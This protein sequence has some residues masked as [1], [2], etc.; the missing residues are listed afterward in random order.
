MISVSEHAISESKKKYFGDMGASLCKPSSKPPRKSDEMDDSISEVS[1]RDE[2]KRV[3]LEKLPPRLFG[4]DVSKATL[5]EDTILDFVVLVSQFTGPLV[6]YKGSVWDVPRRGK[7][8]NVVHSALKP[9]TNIL[10]TSDGQYQLAIWHLDDPTEKSLDIKV[11]DFQVTALCDDPGAVAII[12]GSQSGAVYSLSLDTRDYQLALLVTTASP[13]TLISCQRDFIL[14]ALKSGE[15]QVFNPA[16]GQVVQKY[17]GSPIISLAWSEQQPDL[18]VAC[19]TSPLSLKLH[20]ARAAVS[21]PLAVSFD[22]PPSRITWVGKEL[23][24]LTSDGLFKIS[25]PNSG[26]PVLV[27]SEISDC[28]RNAVLLKSGVVSP[29]PLDDLEFS[30]CT[31]LDFASGEDPWESLGWIIRQVV[32]LKSPETE[33]EA[34]FLSLSESGDS[35]RS[36]I[37]SHAVALNLPPLLL[38]TLPDPSAVALGRLPG[39]TWLLVRGSA[40]GGVRADIL[41]AAPSGPQVSD[42]PELSMPEAVHEG[43]RI[44][45][46]HVEARG[47]GLVLLIVLDDSGNLSISKIQGNQEASVIYATSLVRCFQFSDGLLLTMAGSGQNVSLER[48]QI[49]PRT[50]TPVDDDFGWPRPDVVDFESAWR[51]DKCFADPVIKLMPLVGDGSV[52]L[53]L[54]AAE[55]AIYPAGVSEMFDAP[56]TDAIVYFIED[57][58]LVSVLF[59]GVVKTYVID[60]LASSQLIGTLQLQDDVVT[61]LAPQSLVAASHRGLVPLLKR[62]LTETKRQLEEEKAKKIASLQTAAAAASDARRDAEAK[63]QAAAEEAARLNTT[64]QAVNALFKPLKDVTAQTVRSVAAPL[65]SVT[66][67]L[68]SVAADFAKVSEGV[69]NAVTHARDKIRRNVESMAQLQEQTEEMESDAADFARLAKQL[70]KSI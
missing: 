29:Y 56:A 11:V 34:L 49:W 6:M 58:Q 69:F 50:S 55:M 13:V 46:I 52:V 48:A 31:L 39:R 9:S 30:T 14:L 8:K 24:V 2:L 57:C 51:T 15:I 54:S 61:R 20:S 27:S 45:K 28:G 18:F 32:I 22:K 3:L 33:Y 16:S 67:P 37:L 5:L 62:Q 38:P 36:T 25:M 65:K 68:K 47:G 35:F 70:E 66:A 4:L 23:R 41:S 44:V 17:T 43:C 42:G 1:V 12:I 40:T 63:A 19:R 26:T 59:P 21:E 60:D 53:C 10:V 7:V 64:G